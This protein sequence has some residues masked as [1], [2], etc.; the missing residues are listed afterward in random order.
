MNST[1]DPFDIWFEEERGS[2]PD[3]EVESDDE[4]EMDDYEDKDD[5]IFA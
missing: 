3:F 2:S 4:C 1:P 5:S